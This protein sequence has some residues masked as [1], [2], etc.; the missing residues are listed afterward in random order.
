MSKHKR[1]ITI[2]PS[3]LVRTKMIIHAKRGRS[4]FPPHPTH[5]IRQLT[6]AHYR[7]CSDRRRSPRGTPAGADAPG[8]QGQDKDEK[9]DEEEGE[10]LG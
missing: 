2:L 5:A 6:A 10:G 4:S 3:A 1:Y 7:Y 9:E 8:G